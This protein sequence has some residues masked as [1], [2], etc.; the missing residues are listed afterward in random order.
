MGST[1]VKLRLDHKVGLLRVKRAS[2]ATSSIHDKWVL[3]LHLTRVLIQPLLHTKRTA[4]WIVA[5]IIHA[6]SIRIIVLIGW[7]MVHR[8]VGTAR[9]RLLGEGKKATLT[10]GTG[11]AIWVTPRP[12]RQLLKASQT[13]KGRLNLHILNR[14]VIVGQVERFTYHDP[15][16]FSS[17]I[18]RQPL[19]F[20]LL[21]RMSILYR[22]IHL[23]IATHFIV[24]LLF[25]LS[26]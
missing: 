17:L 5:V 15:T 20:Y 25:L 12:S 22:P 2:S 16:L 19:V 24:R 6:S 13:N 14:Q 26:Q 4:V 1:L 11:T 10:L 7:T 18:W 9:V 23:D 8:E 21:S 3:V